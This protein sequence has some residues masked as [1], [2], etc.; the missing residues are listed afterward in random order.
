MRLKNYVQI[1]DQILGFQSPQATQGITPLGYF[2]RQKNKKKPEPSTE[3][4]M[5]RHLSPFQSKM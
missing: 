2:F 4:I 1:Y 3:T 5:R